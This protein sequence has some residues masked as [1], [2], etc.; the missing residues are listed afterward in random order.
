MRVRNVLKDFN[1]GKL[2][3]NE[4]EKAILYDCEDTT[5]NEV[6][7]ESDPDPELLKVP[8][9]V[10]LTRDMVMREIDALQP[11]Q[12]EAVIAQLRKLCS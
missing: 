11:D 5:Y 10:P 12:R 6:E 9:K 2:T 8:V 1:A 7:D 3:L 4:A